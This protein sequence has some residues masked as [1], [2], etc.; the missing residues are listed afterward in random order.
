MKKCPFCAEEIQDEAVVCRYCGRELAPARAHLT[1]TPTPSP[2]PTPKPATIGPLVGS[3]GVGCMTFLVGSIVVVSLA[4]TMPKAIVIAIAF[5]AL[6]GGSAYLAI[7]GRLSKAYG[8]T[9]AVVAL[10]LSL[11]AFGSVAQKQREAAEAQQRAE[12]QRRQKEQEE[13]RLAD[14]RAAKDQNFAEG[15]RLLAAGKPDES[16]KTLNLVQQ[17]DPQYAGLQSMLADAQGAVNR[18]REARLLADLKGIPSSES[19]KLRDIY[20]ELTALQPT[21]KQY[22]RSFEQY[23]Q[24]ASA[25]ELKATQARVRQQMRASA[26]LEVRSWNWHMSYCQV[27]WIGF[28]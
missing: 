7:R 18:A 10:L 19:Q 13:Q 21:N 23:S 6:A 3:L 5:L 28:A 14:L 15:K 25:E 26:K 4:T 16:L 17:V 22:Q 9:V 1:R 24:R 11:T 12:Q 2:K 20:R 8:I 27:L